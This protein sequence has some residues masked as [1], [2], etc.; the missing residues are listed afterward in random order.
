VSLDQLGDIELERHL[1]AAQVEGLGPSFARWCRFAAM[2]EHPVELQSLAVRER[3]GTRTMCAHTRAADAEA[4]LAVGEEF[5]GTGVYVVANRINDAVTTRVEPGRWHRLERG[6]STSDRDIVA[7]HVVFIDIDAIRPTGTSANDAE[8]ALTVPVMGAVVRRLGLFFG[9]ARSIGVGHSGNG[10]QVFIALEPTPNEAEVSETV[11]RLLAALA[12]LHAAPGVAIDD[13]CHDARRLVPAFGTTKR[14]GSPSAPDR[15]HRRTAFVCA[16]DVERIAWSRVVALRDALEHEVTSRVVVADE[17]EPAKRARPSARRPPMSSESPFARANALPAR[18]IVEWLGLVE[19]GVTRCPGCGNQDGVT[20]LDHGLKCHHRSCASRGVPGRP[21][22][23]TIVDLVAE[24]RGVDARGALE[25]LS[26]RYPD[27]TPARR[28][29]RSFET[30]ASAVAAWRAPSVGDAFDFNDTGNAERLVALH[31]IDMRH[32]GA[33]RRWLVWDGKR[34]SLDELNRVQLFAKN[35]SAQLA[36]EAERADVD[37]DRAADLMKFALRAGS[38]GSRE[39]M[40][41]LAAP[42][43][44]VAIAHERLDAQ[45]MRLSC[46]N[47]TLDLRTGAL[48]P[49]LRADLLTKMSPVRYDANA[50][51]PRWL[52]F[53]HTIMGGNADL[54]A[55]LKRAVGYSLTGDVS[56]QVL[57]FLHGSGSNGKSTFT[58]V[59]QDVMGEHAT[60][61]PPDLLIAKKNPN[62]PT[63]LTSLF[64]ARLAVCQ[65]VE[66]GA[67]FAEVTLKQLTG[68]DLIA[69]RRMRED[70]WYFRPTHKL[71]IA[72]N[73]KPNVRGI[74]H[75]MWRRIRL[76][77]FA[78]TIADGA[79]DPH[80]PEKLATELPGILRWAVEGCL[81]WQRVGLAPPPIVLAATEEYREE[82]DMIGD[83][84]S[85]RC[86]VDPMFTCSAA[87]MYD[88]YTT[89]C[90]ENHHR[91]MSQR[92]VAERLKQKACTPFRGHAGRRMWR[93]VRVRDATELARASYRDSSAEPDAERAAIQGYERDAAEHDT[94]ASN[95]QRPT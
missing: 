26:Q 55:F 77:P 81:E 21:G 24:T 41:A 83:F 73:H 45:H 36:I 65:E 57:F 64:G 87:S 95:L 34:W 54:I 91:P 13:G 89:W 71:W 52:A 76:V 62:H 46:A 28:A 86:A 27:V 79:K 31:G 78:I 19:S 4:L 61:A 58:R 50:D 30:P 9:G 14:K 60:Q 82:Q 7:R 84:L 11:R 48:G 23:R 6:A 53:L 2:G 32:C 17:P 43:V 35:V 39:A 5:P 69:A 16:R 22:F 92:A 20:L 72:G 33:W 18:E 42:E 68:G 80:L 15:P 56:E 88:A 59:L 70:Y 75:A 63:E 37:P 49:H 74:D 85:E 44:G 40:V 94:C 12:Q 93:G 10:R 90:D 47:G 29:E 38:R 3:Y 1:L 66:A 51:C 67:F 25:L 8:M